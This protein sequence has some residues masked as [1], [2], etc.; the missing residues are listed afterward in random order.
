VRNPRGIP[1]SA[2]ES[3]RNRYESPKRREQADATRARFAASA[4]RLFAQNGYAATTIQSIAQDAGLAVQTFYATY[5]S[6]KAVL[7][8]LLDEMED[9]ADLV[10]EIQAAW[11]STD[12]RTQL[13]HVIDF[14]MRFYERGADVI[15]I[16]L[17][18]GRAE[19]ELAALAREGDSRRREGQA[20][21]VHKWAS[22]GALKPGLSASE[23]SDVMWA[24]TSPEAF[25]LFVK[26]QDWPIPRY[27]EWLLSTL[28]AL[29]FDSN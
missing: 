27:R 18:A 17:D 13:A 29:L 8:A 12:P 1:F 5:G 4:R 16:A 15:D 28:E 10:G 25:R 21:F 22:S 9:V 2:K 3:R 24:L 7:F 20:G 6:K 11:A 19:P 14:N 26:A 23:A